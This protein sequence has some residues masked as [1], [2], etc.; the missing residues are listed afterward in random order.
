PW[1]R[2][3]R[4]RAVRAR[5][6]ATSSPTWSLVWSGPAGS[7]SRILAVRDPVPR[8]APPVSAHEDAQLRVPAVGDGRR[9]LEEVAAVVA[10]LAA[11]RPSLQMCVRG[12]D[13]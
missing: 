2:S 10:P 4:E 6:N 9:G 11:G 5:R 8:L 13:P 3:T 12:E 1:T 7:A